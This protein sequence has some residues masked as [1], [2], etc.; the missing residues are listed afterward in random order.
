[1]IKAGTPIKM[2]IYAMSLAGDP[3]YSGCEA[4]VRNGVARDGERGRG[5]AGG[6]IEP[7]GHHDAARISQYA[8]SGVS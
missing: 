7:A 2:V 4:I 1:V 5:A 6:F 3:G 8:T